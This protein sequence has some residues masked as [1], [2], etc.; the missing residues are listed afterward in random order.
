MIVIFTLRFSPG[1]K[2]YHYC[3]KHCKNFE[4]F[5]LKLINQ[6]QTYSSM[7]RRSSRILSNLKKNW[8]WADNTDVSNVNNILPIILTLCCSYIDKVLS[9]IW[10]VCES[11]KICLFPMRLWYFWIIYFSVSRFQVSVLRLCEYQKLQFDITFVG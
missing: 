4:I 5:K 6:A 7:E 1:S 8:Y 10:T 11:Y 2:A 3:C 9:I